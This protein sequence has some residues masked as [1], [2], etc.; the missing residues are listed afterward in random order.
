MP[1]NGMLHNPGGEGGG[2]DQHECQ[3]PHAATGSCV[4]GVRV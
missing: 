2:A 4:I 3:P 1:Q